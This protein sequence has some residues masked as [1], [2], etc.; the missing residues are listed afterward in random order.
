MTAQEPDEVFIE[1]GSFAVTAVD[2]TGLF[3]P[4]AHGMAPRAISTSCYHG[5]VGRYAVVEQRL[6]LRE[7]QLGSAA[8]PPPLAGVRPRQDED[9]SWHYRGLELPIDFTGRLL[10][11]RGN[12]ADRPY[13]TMGFRPAW[14]YPDVRELTFQAGALLSATDCSAALA[15]VR[16]AV[17]ATATRP[18]PGEETRDWIDRTFSLTYAYSWPGRPQ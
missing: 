5:H 8:E 1:G 17:A 2:G 7:L 15:E 9:E 10:I 13:L 11:G 18:A 16:A 3:D 6:T 14:L 4:A 12:L